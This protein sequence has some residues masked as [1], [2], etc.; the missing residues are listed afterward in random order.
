[1]T[2][3][4]PWYDKFRKLFEL[5]PNIALKINA[6]GNWYISS[7]IRL[8][9]GMG[10][11]EII[12]IQDKTPEQVVSKYWEFAVEKAEADA[13]LVIGLSD[14]VGYRWSGTKWNQV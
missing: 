12:S 1:M 11:S 2:I 13:K 6:R 9:N 7:Q 14:K 3:N 5:D 8:L 4:I 10:I